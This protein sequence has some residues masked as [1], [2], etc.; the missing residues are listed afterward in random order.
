MRCMESH[1]RHHIPPAQLQR[2]N[3]VNRPTPLGTKP[4]ESKSTNRNLGS[5]S[6]RLSGL[7]C[8][9]GGVNSSPMDPAHNGLCRVLTIFYVDT[10]LL[11]PC[12]Q[13]NGLLQATSQTIGGL[14]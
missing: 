4:A 11:T 13:L 8:V 14:L 12:R 2:Q 6:D 10:K 9:V 7:T 1:L 5:L 3:T